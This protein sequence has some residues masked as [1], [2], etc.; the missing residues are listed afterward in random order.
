MKMAPVM[1]VLLVGAA[2]AAP[3]RA[4]ADHDLPPVIGLTLM[5]SDASRHELQF[6]P[7]VTPSD[8]AAACETLG[9]QDCAP[10][11]RRAQRAARTAR[12][13]AHFP[14]FDPV[15]SATSPHT[16]EAPFG[17]FEQA[18]ALRAATELDLLGPVADAGNSSTAPPEARRVVEIAPRAPA[19]ATGASAA[20]LALALAERGL[21]VDSFGV[22]GTPA[23][24]KVA[25][26]QAVLR[27]EFATE[28]RLHEVARSA[29][30]R[31]S[32][33]GR[34]DA[35]AKN[36]AASQRPSSVVGGDAPLLWPPAAWNAVS[37]S[38]L[39]V[40]HGCAAADGRSAPGEGGSAVRAAELPALLQFAPPG[41]ALVLGRSCGGAD[42]AARLEAM[43]FA[44]RGGRDDPTLS[45]ATP[46][47]RDDPDVRRDD[48]DARRDD[49]DAR[50]GAGHAS[51]WV[52]RSDGP[53]EPP[54]LASRAS[55]AGAP[56]CGPGGAGA[57]VFSAPRDA[58]TLFVDA[59]YGELAF[60]WD[61]GCAARGLDVAALHDAA[62]DDAA[63]DDAAVGADLVHR[64]GRHDVAADA[65]F[66]SCFA[67]LF[68]SFV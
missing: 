33:A 23:P 40:A 5:A 55:S 12:L 66:V 59:E 9:V 19:G 64:Q 20:Y 39:V 34:A 57:G 30:G 63:V 6:T 61:L 11:Q 14:G 13:Y 26:V 38:R 44:R 60:S 21:E 1:A 48:P 36:S 50:R 56:R 67:L 47:G 2:L 46:A 8:V 49:P 10:L 28:L 54:A 15:P 16:A 52:R 37:R 65:F 22:G 7:R 53:V 31:R 24:A 32:P 27:S 3:A 41:A 18:G 42:T 25:R 45:D 43:G 35:N 58:Q 68:V 51:V 4:D 62:V 17:T 29:G